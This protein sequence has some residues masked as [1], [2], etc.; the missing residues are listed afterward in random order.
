MINVA[1]KN[2]YWSSELIAKVAHKKGSPPVSKWTV[3][4]YLKNAGWLKRMPLLTPKQKADR[5]KRAHENLNRNWENVCISDESIFVLQQ[6]R[7]GAKTD[8][9]NQCPNILLG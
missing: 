9:R 6:Q 4:R 7:F 5:V 2:N 3:L 8:A 1:R